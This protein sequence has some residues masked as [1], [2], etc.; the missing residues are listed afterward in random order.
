VRF[1]GSV[2]VL[3]GVALLLANCG[4]SAHPAATPAD[5]VAPP[6]AAARPPEPALMTCNDQAC[7][8][9]RARIETCMKT[10]PTVTKGPP[11]PAYFGFAPCVMELND[12]EYEDWNEQAIPPLVWSTPGTDVF[13]RGKHWHVYGRIKDAADQAAAWA[14]VKPGFFASG[15]KEAAEYHAGGFGAVMRY[16]QPGIDAWAEVSPDPG[17]V[18]IDIIE[19]GPPPIALTLAQPAA[20]PEKVDPAKGDFPFLAS[21]PGSKLTGGSHDPGPML[22]TLPGASQPDVV[23]TG[24]VAKNYRPADGL[25]LVEWFTLYRGALIKAGWTIVN[26]FRSADGAITAHYAQNGRN[27]WAYLHMNVDG[28][29]IQVGDEGVGL[30]A[31][32][33]KQCHLALTGVLFDFDKA[34]LKAESDPVLGRVR[35]LLAGEPALKLEVQG[36]TDNVG[37]DDYNLALSNARA[38]AVVAWLTQHGI[39]GGRLTARGYGKTIPVA[40][41]RTDEGR[42]KNRRVEIA[43]P[44]CAPSRK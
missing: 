22:V 18:L 16:T 33:A 9:A 27:I 5:A 7:A 26:E 14:A 24:S 13:K 44:T 12:V 32:L 19:V 10:P 1:V 39:E 21:L 4:K 29:S 3:L 41:N 30:A 25:S 34:T 23:A 2:A 11:L 31:G 40:D 8:S 42:A 20:S 28:Y 38:A 15:W 35:D 37:A 36:H 43:D 17:T 6:A